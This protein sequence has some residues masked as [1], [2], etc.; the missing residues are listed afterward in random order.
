MCLHW[1]DRPGETQPLVDKALALDPNNYYLEG[2][3]GWHYF[4]LKNWDE[5]ERWFKAAMF[6]ANWHPD[7]YNKHYE[8]AEIYLRLI[9][10]KRQE[11]KQ[12][13]SGKG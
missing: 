5:S 3:V 7:F 1:L 12:E 11:E 10:G 2:L 13:K 4:Q 8:T 9:E 6:K